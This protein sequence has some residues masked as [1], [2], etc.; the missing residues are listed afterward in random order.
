MQTIA[1]WACRA[2]V[3]TIVAVA[4]TRLLKHLT[5]SSGGVAGLPTITGD[6]WPPVPVKTPR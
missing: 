5:A 6:T 2:V 1:G 4:A 3:L